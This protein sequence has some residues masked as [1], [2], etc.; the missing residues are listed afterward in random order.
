MSM[1]DK[2]MKKSYVTQNKLLIVKDSVK[3]LNDTSSRLIALF[4]ITR[5]ILMAHVF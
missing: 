1:V 3:S 4:E 2:F 5:H